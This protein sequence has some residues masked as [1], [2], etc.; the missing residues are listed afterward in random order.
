MT[1]LSFE[2]TDGISTADSLM[3][4]EPAAM[5]AAQEA[6]TTTKSG[7]FTIDSIGFH[8]S[9]SIQDTPYPSITHSSLQ[10]NLLAS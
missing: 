9:L 1:G 7:P 8:A 5:A 6:Y 10:T 2:V 4:R 3:R